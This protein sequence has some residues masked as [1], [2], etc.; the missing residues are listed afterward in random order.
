MKDLQLYLF[1]KCLFKFLI[2]SI[3]NSFPLSNSVCLFLFKPDIH[4]SFFRLYILSLSLTV[5]PLLHKYQYCHL[6][7]HLSFNPSQ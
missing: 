5:I 2:C 4:D 6:K 7:Y 1:S 3:N